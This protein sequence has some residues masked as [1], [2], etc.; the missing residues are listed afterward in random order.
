MLFS[1]GSR[2]QEMNRQEIRARLGEMIQQALIRPKRRRATKPT[3][4]S[5]LKRLE[6]QAK[7]S[8]VKAARGRPR[9]DD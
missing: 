6:E 8:G 1:Q 7:R 5:K 3:Y 4:A 2:S 9:H